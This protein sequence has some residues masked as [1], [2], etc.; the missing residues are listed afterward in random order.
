LFKSSSPSQSQI[1]IALLFSLAGQWAC[2]SIS[3]SEDDNSTSDGAATG[4]NSGD[5]GGNGAT[6]GT[7]SAE[8]SGA[9][10]ALGAGGGAAV[11]TATGGAMEDTDLGNTRDEVR[12][13]CDPAQV[14]DLGVTKLRRLTKTQLNN[15]LR[16]LFGTGAV[17][18]ADGLAPDETVGPFHS[19]SIAPV[20]DLIVQQL[21]EVAAAAAADATAMSTE[22]I[23]CDLVGETTTDCASEFVQSFASRAFRRPVTAEEETS[24]VDLFVLGR[25]G[26]SP[27]R[28]LDLLLRAILQSGSFLYLADD[29]VS[30]V[31]SAAPEAVTSHTLA[32]RLSF[33]LWNSIPDDA[34]KAAADDGTLLDDGVYQAQVERLLADPKAQE[35]IALFHQRW[36]DVS[37]LPEKEKDGV[38]FPEFNI[39]LAE[40]MLSD[41][42]RFANQIIL[43]GDG[44]LS[45]LLS[46]PTAYPSAALAEIYGVAAP[47]A[48][49]AVVELPPDQRGGLLTQPAFLASHARSLD[50]SPVHRGIIIREHMLCETIQP[51]PAGV[52]TDLPDKTEATTTR[53]QFEQHLQNP[54]CANCHKLIDPIGLAFE[55]Y[56]AIGRW[57]ELDGLG[58]IDTRGE[59]VESGDDVAGEFDGV[60]ELSAKLSQSLAVSDCVARQWFRFALQRLESESDAC[61]M[62]SLFE[63][64]EASGGNVRSLITQIAMS[65][66]FRN[67]RLTGGDSQ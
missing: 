21:A 47:S 1:A 20:T 29:G 33:F 6:M 12:E 10:N 34:L 28:G 17:T 4:A 61:S 49:G 63:D 37:E 7:G 52:S 19:N 38:V 66:A 60:I 40:D 24:L 13:S 57:R 62:L 42:G 32:S 9:A 35:A 5:S 23:S 44:L 2:S 14:L 27:E 22:F 55:H 59:V 51:P 58:E 64:F 36:L 11:E 15:S 8:G 31:P 41:Q 46:S 43:D 39:G 54:T 18:Y 50:S 67:V 16:D 48:E 45:T 30:G 3:E 53:E 26:T 65:D 56:N 25:D